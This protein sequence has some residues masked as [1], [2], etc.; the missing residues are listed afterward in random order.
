VSSSEKTAPAP[1]PL[2]PPAHQN[3]PAGQRAPDAIGRRLSA[4]PAALP[5][6]GGQPAQVQLLP[7]LALEARQECS[8]VSFLQNLLIKQKI[9]ILI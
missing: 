7:P 8:A 2:Q 1:L 9:L 5:R 6:P 4:A 3:R